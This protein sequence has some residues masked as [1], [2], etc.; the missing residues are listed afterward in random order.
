MNDY[1]AVVRAADG[2]EETLSFEA[3]TRDEA[4]FEAGRF[5]GK[6]YSG[7]WELVRLEEGCGW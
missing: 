2:R 6:N 4:L 3:A 1:I 7:R 5:V